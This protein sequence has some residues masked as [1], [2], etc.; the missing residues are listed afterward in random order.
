MSITWVKINL[1]FYCNPQALYTIFNYT[2]FCF[3]NMYDLKDQNNIKS[4]LAILLT[5]SFLILIFIFIL[6]YFSLIP[7]SKNFPQYFGWLPYIDKQDMNES[8]LSAR[9]VFPE[10]FFLCPVKGEQ[11]K[12]GYAVLDSERS[13]V[14]GIGYFYLLRDTELQAM[15]DGKYTV[16][17]LD[18]GST[19]VVLIDKDENIEVTY[20]F[21]DANRNESLNFNS[22]QDI[23]RGQ[24]V[25]FLSDSEAEIDIGTARKYALVVYIRNLK[26][27]ESVGVVLDKETG[28]VIIK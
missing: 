3:K 6:N 14:D 26:S 9:R 25:Y 16:S 15:M 28:R 7:L 2:R 19:Q 22:N 1:T 27:R 23:E 13:R 21:N 8:D 4:R 20:I 17:N 5:F 12:N 18:D 11:C 10:D 24:T